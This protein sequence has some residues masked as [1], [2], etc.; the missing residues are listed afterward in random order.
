MVWTLMPGEETP[1]AGW[2]PTTARFCHLYLLAVCLELLTGISTA[3]I[4]N[5]TAS[6]TSNRQLRRSAP[7]MLI[8]SIMPQS[9]LSSSHEILLDNHGD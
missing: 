3:T 2:A 6:T 7:P 1:S 4:A 5:T 9:H 8:G